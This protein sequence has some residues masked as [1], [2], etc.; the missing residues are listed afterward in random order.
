MLDIRVFWQYSVEDWLTWESDSTLDS[1]LVNLFY[2][3]DILT[4]KYYFVLITVW[5]HKQFKEAKFLLKNNYFGLS[6]QITAMS[7]ITI[8]KE[9]SWRFVLVCVT[10]L[11]PP[12]I[13][14]LR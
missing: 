8:A 12:G 10:F 11:L 13:K 4:V 9:I 5:F 14:G 1:T 3:L 7:F 6:V 2:I